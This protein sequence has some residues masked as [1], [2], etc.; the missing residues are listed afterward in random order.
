MIYMPTNPLTPT[1]LVELKI[2]EPTSTPPVQVMI[3]AKAAF[4]EYA[5]ME[6]LVC[7]GFVVDS[8]KLNKRLEIL[9]YSRV[10]LVGDDGHTLMYLQ[11]GIRTFVSNMVTWLNQIGHTTIDTTT[12]S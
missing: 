1:I 11:D 2:R 9:A 4:Y 7:S 6:T 3:G 12:S 8:Y 10:T 5:P